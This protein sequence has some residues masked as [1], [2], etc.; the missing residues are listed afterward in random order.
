L[1]ACQEEF[2]TRNRVS[3]TTDA[4]GKV[5][6]QRTPKEAIMKKLNVIKL[7]KRT[8]PRYIPF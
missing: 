7:E 3:G 6:K 2:A 1:F 5:Q 4:L 8:A